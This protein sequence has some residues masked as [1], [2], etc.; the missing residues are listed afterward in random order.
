MKNTGPKGQ[1]VTFT[2]M[3]MTD[4]KTTVTGIYHG[5][6][7]GPPGQRYI[8]WGARTTVEVGR[9]TID[10]SSPEGSRV[11]LIPYWRELA[12]KHAT[13]EF[14]AVDWSK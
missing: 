9:D 14:P 1:P 6:M 2:S 4:G 3:I 12:A 11:Y 10:R 8:N 5:L 7:V 13:P